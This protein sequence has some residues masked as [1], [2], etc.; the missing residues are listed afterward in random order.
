MQ[1]LAFI[2][3][4]DA[5]GSETALHMW[6][7]DVKE[8]YDCIPQKDVIKA[9][10]WV[11]M[12][13]KNKTR[14][15]HVAVNFKNSK[16][17]H[18]G[19]VCESDE[20]INMP[21]ET[22]FNIYVFEIS[23]AFFAFNKK[24]FLQAVGVP[25]GAPGSPGASMCVC[26]FYEQQFRL[27]IYDHSKFIFFFRYFDDLRAIVAYRPR[28]VSS[29]NLCLNLI[30]CLKERTYH[31]K[32]SLELEECERNSFKFLEGQTIMSKNY[33]SMHWWSKNF[34]S[35]LDHGKLKFLTSQDYFSYSG[36]KRKIVRAATVSGRLA[37]ILGYSF[38]DS[39][40]IKSFGYLLPELY[41][42]KYPQKS[43][44]SA[45]T[46]KWLETKEPIWKLICALVKSCFDK[47]R[48]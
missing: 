7:A 33:F 17:S 41:A 46:K 19:K 31:P 27:S 3:L 8:M 6:A 20:M 2:H 1:K 25:I 4:N 16:L 5:Y 28:D 23:N 44:V 24:V 10:K 11:L 34:Q 45:C 37:S 15:D 48:R 21:F 38:S 14:R 47:M 13:V 43:I 32:M 26:I 39:D 30:K 9:I 22:L 29:K 35:L 40:V 12:C 18:L 36:D 42:R